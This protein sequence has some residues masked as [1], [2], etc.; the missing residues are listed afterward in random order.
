MDTTATSELSYSIHL[1]SL[2]KQPSIVHCWIPVF[3]LI[4]VA[5]LSRVSSL[6]PSLLFIVF[7]RFTTRA[8]AALS[9]S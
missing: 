4:S 1:I 7:K 5:F 9:L 2:A 3:A 8:Y 6:S